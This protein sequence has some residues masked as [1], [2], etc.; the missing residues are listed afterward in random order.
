MA[1]AFV[2]FYKEDTWDIIPHADIIL[3]EE[4]KGKDA[5]ELEGLKLWLYGE[6]LKENRSRLLLK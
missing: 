3:N 2:N 1:F 4:H 6:M 5:Q